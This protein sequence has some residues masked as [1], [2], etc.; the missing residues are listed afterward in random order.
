M[1]TPPFALINLLRAWTNSPGASGHCHAGARTLR[2]RSGFPQSQPRGLSAEFLP[3]GALRTGT[4]RAPLQSIAGCAR[5]RL[6]WLA[7]F[8]KSGPVPEDSPRAS[9]DAQPRADGRHT[10]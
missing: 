5:F 2:V 3:A 1:L 7:Q 6:P 8:G 4:V 10:T 9:D